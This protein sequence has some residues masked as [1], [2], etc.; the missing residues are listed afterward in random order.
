MKF[1]YIL[2]I[3]LVTFIFSCN[4]NQ[5]TTDKVK[6]IHNQKVMDISSYTGNAVAF[7]DNGHNDF[8]S[9]YIIPI[10]E[11]DSDIFKQKS[12]DI[13]NGIKGRC[14]I[15]FTIDYFL[16]DLQNSASKKK[17]DRIIC[18]V[19]ANYYAK[20]WISYS[21]YEELL[22]KRKKNSHLIVVK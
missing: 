19:H 5:K 1:R 6:C 20:I 4:N 15:N 12:F 3:V 11:K 17:L 16:Y 18:N 21:K 22:L 9:A 13:F 8:Y 14:S 7:F 10:L 2:M